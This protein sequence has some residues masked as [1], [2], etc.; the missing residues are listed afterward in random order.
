MIFNGTGSNG[1]FVANN[2]I[3]T[4]DGTIKV[5]QDFTPETDNLNPR[6]QMSKGMYI[7]NEGTGTNNKSIEV[8]GTFIGMFTDGK[9]ANAIN[10]RYY[11][12]KW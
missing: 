5:T 8:Q 10:N 9:N 11:H 12:I 2:S 1:M 3:A 6:I 4:N 7:L